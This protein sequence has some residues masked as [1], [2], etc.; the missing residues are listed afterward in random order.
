MSTFAMMNVWI[1]GHNMTIIE[2]DGVLTK[3]FTVQILPISSAQRY[4]VLVTALPSNSLNYYMHI[5]FE[6]NM[7]GDDPPDLYNNTAFVNIEY[8]VNATYAPRGDQPSDPMKFDDMQIEPL[9]PEVSYK[10]DLTKRF[11]G[12]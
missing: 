5:Q 4:S 3:P 11:D 12:K 2:V 10:P 9:I 8:D 7:F 1:D 6:E